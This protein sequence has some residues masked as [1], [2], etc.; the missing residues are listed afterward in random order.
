[1]FTIEYKTRVGTFEKPRETLEEIRNYE[2]YITSLAGFEVLG[3]YED[4]RELDD[5]EGAEWGPVRKGTRKP[6]AEQRA[7]EQE[8]ELN[9][10][11]TPKQGSISDTRE[12]KIYSHPQQTTWGTPPRL[13]K[14]DARNTKRA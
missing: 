10:K 4:G 1:M 8:R 11:Y 7:P 6:L 12:K 13:H 5:S 2:K 3:V 14:D 9:K